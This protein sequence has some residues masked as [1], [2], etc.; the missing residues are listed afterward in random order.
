MPLFECVDGSRDVLSIIGTGRCKISSLL[1]SRFCIGS[2]TTITRLRHEQ[3]YQRWW[4][5]C[6]HQQGGEHSSV[7]LSK[8]IGIIFITQ[9]VFFIWLRWSHRHGCNS[10]MGVQ[11]SWKNESR[12]CRKMLSSNRQRALTVR[13]KRAQLCLRRLRNKHPEIIMWWCTGLP[14][15][16]SQHCDAIAGNPVHQQKCMTRSDR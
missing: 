11:W 14:A 1:H 7:I 6:W 3:N 16:A 4:C 8:N 13:E 10:P 5:S 2:G 15:M 12:N 9:D